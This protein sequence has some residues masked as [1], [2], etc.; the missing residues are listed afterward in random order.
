MPGLMPGIS[1]Y[2]R[3]QFERFTTG[4]P[5]EHVANSPWHCLAPGTAEGTLVGGYL[6]NFIFATA[7]GRI[8]LDEGRRYVLFL[9]DNERF[10]R[11]EAES[12]HIARLEQCGILP[13]VSGLLFGHY[14]KPSNEHLLERLRRL[15]EKWN[16]PVAYCDD[17]G[18]GENHAILPIGAEAALDTEQHALRY[19]W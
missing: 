14:S 8:P 1:E 11:I 15:G 7:T 18:H 2:N 9:E 5:R 16:I 3:R 13:H 10:F 19:K 17:F 12:A 4:L 6:A